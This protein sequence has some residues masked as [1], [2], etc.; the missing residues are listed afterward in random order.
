MYKCLL[1]LD[2]T[3]MYSSQWIS[4]IRTILNNCGMSGIWL[5]QQVNNPEWLKNAVERKLKDQWITT[6]HSNILTKG[7]C[8]SYNMYK[9]LYALEDYLVKLRKPIRIPD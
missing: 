8:K 5:D 1:Y 4:H 9:E 3:G 7:I 6:W 2:S